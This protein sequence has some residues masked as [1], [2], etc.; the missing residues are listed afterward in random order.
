MATEAPQM[1]QAH[2]RPALSSQYEAPRTDAERLLV[3]IW[4]QMLGIEQIGIHDNF[5]ELGGD[6]VINIQITARAN[7]AGLKFTPR[8]AFENQTIASL[9]AAIVAKAAPIQD[10][11]ASAR[12]K[13]E[14]GAGPS[15]KGRSI[16][17]FDLAEIARQLG[18]RGF[19]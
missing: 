2:A 7:K 19:R 16:S 1:T 18:A 9:A 8:Q 15:P 17:D 5:F 3:D 12:P 10:P 11:V 4:T 6:S 14:S 13:A